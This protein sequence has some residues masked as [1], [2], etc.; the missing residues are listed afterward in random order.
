M[1]YLSVLDIYF[2]LGSFRPLKDCKEQNEL[3]YDSGQI[4]DWL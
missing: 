4:M 1:Y 3:I 2:F